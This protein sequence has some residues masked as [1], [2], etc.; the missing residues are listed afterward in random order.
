MILHIEP[1]SIEK[2]GIY[3]LEEQVVVTENGCDVLSHAPW[4]LQAVR[5]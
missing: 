4:K 1:G 3:V 2:D 5:G